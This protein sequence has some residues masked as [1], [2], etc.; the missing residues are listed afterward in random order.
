MQSNSA[1]THALAVTRPALALARPDYIE[2]IAANLRRAGVQ[3]AVAAHDS[4][5]I[6]DWLVSLLSLQGISDRVALTWDAEHGGITWAAIEASLAAPPRCPK[7][8]CH[9]SFSGCGYRKSAMSCKTPAL[10]PT[11]PLPRHD[12]RKGL[13]NRSAHG[14][15]LFIRDICG[16]DLVAWLDSRLVQAAGVTPARAVPAEAD[17]AASGAVWACAVWPFIEVDGISKKI[18]ALSL[19]DLLLA[20]DAS[21]DT[22]VSAGSQVVVV[23]TL[24]HNL[25]IRSGILRRFRAEHAYGA[26]CYAEGGCAEIIK[27]LAQRFDARSVNRSFPRYFPR[28]VQEAL[29]RFASS[30]LGVCNGL[31][32]DDRYRCRNS[33]CP[34]YAD[35][36]RVRLGR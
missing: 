14:L 9:W 12:L 36:D 32:I 3:A 18:A 13:L 11:C 1:W 6:F 7:L 25:L 2:R 10:L 20:G 34:A 16:G 29:W 19:T 4:A 31:R 22:W 28:L 26:A 33:D 17:F 5:T 35:C 23:D 8:R 30:E 27:G 21:R 15:F 24:V